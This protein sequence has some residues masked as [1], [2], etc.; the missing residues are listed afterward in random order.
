MAAQ[1]RAYIVLV[2]HAL[3]L[4]WSR[5]PFSKKQFSVAVLHADVKAPWFSCFW[6]L[7]RTEIIINE[8]SSSSNK[9]EALIFGKLKYTPSVADC[10]NLQF[11]VSFRE[12]NCIWSTF[13]LAVLFYNDFNLVENEEGGDELR[14]LIFLFLSKRT[15][16]RTRTF[17]FSG[18]CV[19]RFPRDCRYN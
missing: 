17:F 15:I 12:S 13:I 10:I 3:R 9:L 2:A 11:S 4:N 6:G 7:C 5:H 16:R 1:N 8:F 18:H 14:A 19:E